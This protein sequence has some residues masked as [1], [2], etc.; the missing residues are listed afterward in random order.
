MPIAGKPL[1]VH[2]IEHALASG[3]CDV[4][5]VSTDSEEIASVARESGAEVLIRPAHLGEDLVPAEPVLQ[6]AL[7]TY[8]A[9]TGRVF[10][11]VVYLQTTDLFRTQDLISECVKRLQS[12]P[13]LDSVFSGYPTHKNYW[14]KEAGKY[15]RVWRPD[16]DYGPRQTADPL[17]REDTGLA[18]ASRADLIR[19]GYRIGPRVDIVLIDRTETGIDIHTQFDFWLATKV[20]TEWTEPDG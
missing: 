10:D 13:E 9:D 1:I 11:I 18:C 6:H 5:L 8:E 17:I 14:R 16:L 19:K 7:L 3:V 4:V 20:L 12:D 15:V 2:T